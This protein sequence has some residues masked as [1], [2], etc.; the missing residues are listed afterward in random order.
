MDWQGGEVV[1]EKCTSDKTTGAN[2]ELQCAFLPPSVRMA[3]RAD[4]E[5]YA[6]VCNEHGKPA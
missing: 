2:V 5:A 6:Q 1:Q 4:A 3:K